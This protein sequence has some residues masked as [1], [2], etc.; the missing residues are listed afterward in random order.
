[1]RQRFYTVTCDLGAGYRIEGRAWARRETA[2]RE[3][4]RLYR[5]WKS[6]GARGVTIRAS[7]G[8]YSETYP[9]RGE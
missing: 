1:M 6:A 3:A 4:R 2:R 8:S 5:T 9:E 7:D